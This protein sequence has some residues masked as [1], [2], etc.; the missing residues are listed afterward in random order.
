MVLKR[1]H[2]R[3]TDEDL[4]SVGRAE[5]SVS[6]TLWPISGKF[7]FHLFL[8]IL[9]KALQVKISELSLLIRGAAEQ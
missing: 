3:K 2:A 6:M 7:C 4:L 5:P 9:Q 1:S 8:L